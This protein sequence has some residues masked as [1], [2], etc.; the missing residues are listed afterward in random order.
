MTRASPAERSNLVL[1]SLG[2][3]LA[4][5]GC[6]GADPGGGAAT[7][8]AP[9][10]VTVA[11]PLVTPITEWYEFTGRFEATESVDVRARVSGYLESVEFTD[12]EIVERGQ[13]LFVIDPRPFEAA[14]EEAR[15]QVAGDGARV[16]LAETELARAGEL[17]DRGTISRS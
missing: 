6:D 12:G 9:P 1:A 10:P 2:L 16:Q 5:A 7:A 11:S 15:A 4:L 8:P 14:L 13:T 17:V 3:S